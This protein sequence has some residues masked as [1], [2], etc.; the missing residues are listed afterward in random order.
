LDVLRSISY[1]E[2][3]PEVVAA[4]RENDFVG[5]D[6]SALAREGDV[7]KVFIALQGAQRGHDVRLKVVPLQAKVFI[8]HHEQ[9]SCIGSCFSSFFFDFFRKIFFYFVLKASVLTKISLRSLFLASRLA[10]V[11]FKCLSER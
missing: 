11:V 5:F 6:A 4:S 2:D 8:G 7:Y 3:I 9:I 10:S 1:P